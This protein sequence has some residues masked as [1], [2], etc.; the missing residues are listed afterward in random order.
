MPLAFCNLQAYTSLVTHQFPFPKP[1]LSEE[2]I[3]L[4]SDDNHI[5]H[6]PEMAAEEELSMSPPQIGSGLNDQSLLDKIDKLFACNVGKYIDL[7][8]LIVVGDQSSGK[9]SV[10]EGLTGLPFPRDSGLCT[11]FATQIIFRRATAKKIVVSILPAKNADDLHVK[12]LAAWQKTD[13]EDLSAANFSSIMKDVS[14]PLSHKVF[15]SLMLNVTGDT[16]YG[17]QVQGRYRQQRST[18]VLA[19]RSSY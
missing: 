6:T 12:T 8:Q 14:H 2:T 19:G 15:V 3:V 10:L 13:L 4:S 18:Y 5:T 11:R 16:N 1:T 17:C 7:P 9:S